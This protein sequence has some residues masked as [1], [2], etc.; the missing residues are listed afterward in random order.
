MNQNKKIGVFNIGLGFNSISKITFYIDIVLLFFT[1][2]Q[3]SLLMTKI[4]R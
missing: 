4:T 2:G 3:L 1:K